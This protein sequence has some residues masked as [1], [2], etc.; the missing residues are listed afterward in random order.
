M[1]KRPKYSVA[2]KL[3]QA[4][5]NGKQGWL[6][7]G[8]WAGH[9]RRWWFPSK[10]GAVAKLADLDKRRKAAGEWWSSLD[11]DR[12]GTLVILREIESR[13]LTLAAVWKD[14][15]ANP[16]T[17]SVTVS[18]AVDSVMAAKSKSN[19]RQSYMDSLRI[20]LNRFALWIGKERQIATVTV[21]ELG[22]F[23]D[24]ID[25][26][27]QQSRA[28]YL[29]RLG[30]L[31]NFAARRRWLADNPVDQV[32]PV[33]VDRKPPAVLS[34]RAVALLLRLASLKT[35][36][37]LP[38]IVM[39]L[40]CGIRPTELQRLDWSKV[41]LKEKRVILDETVAKTRHRRI[42]PIPDNAVAWLTAGQGPV[43]PCR[44][45]LRRRLRT[46]R[47]YFRLKRIPAD[48]L[49]HT[50]ASYLL[51]REQDAGRV[52]TWLGNSVGI[53]QRHYVALVTKEQAGE[54]F[55]LKPTY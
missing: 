14:Y 12:D 16:K 41:D 18:F 45:T 37:A 28:T 22:K 51:A 10:T 17:S 33:T 31:F 40:F 52:A 50:A 38:Y 19:R 55:N 24:S 54:F 25:R 20:A 23:L 7:D 34:C 48:I 1:S 44:V 5:K 43:V 2:M 46:L 30:T 9:R 32:E 8:Q 42:T 26:G 4:S 3:K 35:P 39:G 6:V 47:R 27:S 36:D 11:G 49:R 13:G 15:Q 21:D 29:N 53:L